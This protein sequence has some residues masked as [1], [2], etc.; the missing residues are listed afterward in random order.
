MRAYRPTL[1]V[2]TG[3]SAKREVLRFF[4]NRTIS[5]KTFKISSVTAL[6][7][8]GVIGL[9]SVGTLRAQTC[10]M[11]AG[12]TG[13]QCTPEMMEQSKGMFQN[14]HNMSPDEK[15][16]A[17]SQKMK[18]GLSLNDDQM[19]KVTFVLNDTKATLKQ[20]ME[21]LKNLPKGDAAPAGA[22]EAAFMKLKQDFDDMH[23]K[24]KLILNED[25]QAKLDNFVQ[26]H[27]SRWSHAVEQSKSGHGAAQ[28][29]SPKTGGEPT[30]TTPKN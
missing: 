23:A 27:A 22:R 18:E 11:R 8:A 25:Q 17:I 1:V 28:A 10:P 13:K 2:V 5:M 19:Q 16:A 15:I 26:G 21:T 30:E 4:F 7:V 12:C 29:N 24:F 14:W 9:V 3:G 20:D 6:V